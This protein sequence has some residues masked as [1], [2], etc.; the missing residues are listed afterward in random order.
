MTGSYIHSKL[1]FLWWEFES[2]KCGVFLTQ[3]QY[4]FVLCFYR[5]R[6]E[7]ATWGT[8]LSELGKFGR[9]FIAPFLASMDLEPKDTDLIESL[10]DEVFILS[11]YEFPLT[12]C[13]E[14]TT[15]LLSEIMPIELVCNTVRTEYGNYVNFYSVANLAEIVEYFSGKKIDIDIRKSEIGCYICN[16]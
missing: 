2:S 6:E 8:L 14:K 3:D 13:A 4:D 15:T 12:Q 9:E 10:R 1:I 11:D 7:G 16:Y 5:A